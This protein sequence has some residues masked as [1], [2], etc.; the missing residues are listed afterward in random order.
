MK[1]LKL[2]LPLLVC[3]G[4]GLFLLLGLERDPNAMPSALLDKPI[5]SFS[6]AILGGNTTADQTI[7]QGQPAL[8]NIWATW[9][10]AC[11]IEHPF[12]N[13]LSEQGV[14][15][16]GVNYKDEPA[17]ALR[18]LSSMGDPY[19]LSVMDLNGQ[20]GV[21]LGVFGAPET[22][23]VDSNGIVRAK[24]VGIVDEAVWETKLAPLYE[25]EYEAEMKK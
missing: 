4:L 1:R 19:A 16:I 25:A 7:F 21:N 9:C 5:P 15:I 6:L 14:R 11:R 23:L 18:W 17:A 22:Y 13:K 2:F 10:G 24:H 20:L 3:L 8:L 12:L